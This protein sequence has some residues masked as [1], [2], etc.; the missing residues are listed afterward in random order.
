[1]GVP[2]LVN[3][4]RPLPTSPD[5]RRNPTDLTFLIQ[6]SLGALIPDID[7]V[8]SI[9]YQRVS[10]HRQTYRPSTAKCFLYFLEGRNDSHPKSMRHVQILITSINALLCL[11]S[12]CNFLDA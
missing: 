8:P 5:L 7:G 2:H 6:L 3:G 10:R 9:A 11:A 4:L 12:N 1:M